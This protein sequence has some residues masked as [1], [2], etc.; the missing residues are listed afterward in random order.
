MKNAISDNE[1]NEL[2]GKFGS[3]QNAQRIK[4]D[5]LMCIS[6]GGNRIFSATL[7]NQVDLC[8]ND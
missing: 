1:I 8:Y 6:Q 2:W 5:V 4:D 7:A 3:S